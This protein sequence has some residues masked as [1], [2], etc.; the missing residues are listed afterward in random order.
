[1][2]SVLMNKKYPMTSVKPRFERPSDIAKWEVQQQSI[3]ILDTI[4]GFEIKESRD[5]R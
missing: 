4:K 3:A 5:E 1:M 2:T